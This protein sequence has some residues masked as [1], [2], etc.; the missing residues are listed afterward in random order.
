MESLIESLTCTLDMNGTNGGVGIS[1]GAFL[2]G[3]HF[4]DNPKY[5]P[6]CRRK[7]C[8]S[9]VLKHL[10]KRRHSA[11]TQPEMLFNCPWCSKN[12]RVSVMSSPNGYQEVNLDSDEFA[13]AEYERNLNEINH[14]LIKKLENGIR[15]IEGRINSFRFI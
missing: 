4:L 3:K 9:C 11:A 14:Y 8:N 12:T 1:A 10:S 5:L 2:T 6:C 13:R 15:N 7:A